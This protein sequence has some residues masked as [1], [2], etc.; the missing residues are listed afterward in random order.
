MSK[1]GS[2]LGKVFDEFSVITNKSKECAYFFRG[3]WT[4]YSRNSL[5]FLGVGVNFTISDDVTKYLEGLHE[6]F[7]L[8][9]GNF[10][11][12]FMKSIKDKLDVLKMKFR[13]FR[14]D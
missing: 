7:A 11:T 10:K 1:W 5:S 12:I 8:S 14:K 13:G 2:D 4:G 6:K 9:E 3:G